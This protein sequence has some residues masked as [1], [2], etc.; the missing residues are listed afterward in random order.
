M[1]DEHLCVVRNN[2]PSLGEF[3]TPPGAFTVGLAVTKSRSPAFSFG[4]ESPLTR[5]SVYT[6]GDRLPV[7]LGPDDGGSFTVPREGLGGGCVPV[8]VRFLQDMPS[9][10]CTRAVVLP[11]DG[12]CAGYLSAASLSTQ[13]RVGT[14]ASAVSTATSGY[15]ALSV[16]SV[17]TR[18]WVTGA[19]GAAGAL[20]ATGM[21]AATFD[22][23]RRVCRNAL[24]QVD[25]RV[26]Q[27]GS[28]SVTAVLASVVLWDEVPLPVNATTGVAQ[29]FGVSFFL[30]GQEANSLPR[31]GNPGYVAGLPLLGGRLVNDPAGSGK[32]AIARNVAGLLLPAGRDLAGAC[33]SAESGRTVAR[34]STNMVLSCT[35]SLTVQQL[36]QLCLNQTIPAPLVLPYDYIGTFGNVDPTKVGDWVPITPVEFNPAPQWLGRTCNAIPTAVHLQ[37]ATA[38]YGSVKN[39]QRKV[40]GAQRI[41]STGTWTH[42]PGQTV[43]EFAYTV[44]VSFA[45]LADRAL[46]EVMPASPNP[47]F[48]V[49]RDTL[50][51]F[52]LNS[53]P[54]MAP[55]ILISCIVALVLAIFG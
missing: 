49:P 4:D 15:V 1:I 2:N 32:K 36:A 20:P 16:T 41:V 22:A 19:L 48:K 18:S 37:I 44:T 14:T 27:D 24:A 43:R 25:Y 38:D 7:L 42:L 30:R 23:A 10:A 3:F 6:V 8:P 28:G 51:P 39:P 29:Q 47:F 34:M 9:A 13:L 5:G 53:A 35:V 31:S 21:P 54:S 40:V 12:G 52:D 46:E 33:S 45:H 17:T 50:Y 55:P 26:I 11:W